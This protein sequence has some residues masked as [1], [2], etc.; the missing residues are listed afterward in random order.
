MRRLFTQVG[1]PWTVRI[2]GFINLGC[3]VVGNLLIRPR[4]KPNKNLGGKV[5]DLS[6]LKD[7][8]FTLLGLGIFFSDW[9][10]FGPI[11][12]ITS[13]SLAQGID[14]DLSYYMIPIL[15]V[16]SSLGR[17]VPGLLADKIG[18][19]RPVDSN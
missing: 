6:A 16:G 12:F 8:R 5:I 4:I 15:N 10:L 19:Y 7:M 9:A 2:V 14:S 17:V 18:P 11:T 1:F 13:Y 3:L